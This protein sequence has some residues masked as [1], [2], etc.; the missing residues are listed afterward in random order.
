MQNDESV[1]KRAKERALYLLEYRDH[2]EKE[3]FD[4]LKK[5]YDE[6][7]CANVIAN[8]VEIGLLSDINYANKLANYYLKKWGGRR[9]I[10]E[11][12]RK[13]ISKEVACNAIEDCSIDSYFVLK[14]IIYKKYD[15]T[16]T[17]YKQRQKTIS[18]LLRLGFDYSMIKEVIIEVKQE[19]EE[20]ED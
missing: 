4:K 9:A 16:L 11:M 7:I 6:H 12:Q 5:N 18:A 1:L 15:Y 3:L 19:L 8:L 2:S 17:D 13:G 14:D 20:N 10:L